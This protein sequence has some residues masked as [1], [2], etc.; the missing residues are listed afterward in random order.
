MTG[1]LNNTKIVSTLERLKL[2]K[3]IDQIGSNMK[4]CYEKM[5]KLKLIDEAEMNLLGYWLDEI[6]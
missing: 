6:E 5:I 2:K 3:G 1:Y 4:K